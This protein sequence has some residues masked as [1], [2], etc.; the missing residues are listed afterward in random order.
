MIT[1]EQA[2]HD[3]KDPDTLFAEPDLSASVEKFARNEGYGWAGIL[4]QYA[5]YPSRLPVEAVIPH[6]VYLDTERVAEEELEAPVPA[7]LNYPAMRNT[8][9]ERL[10]D[11]VVVPSASPF[12]YA[13][14]LFRREF[15]GPATTDGTIF[16]PAHA[17]ETM[18]WDVD[19]EALVRTLTA[20]DDEHQPV[21]VCMHM[22]EYEKGF[23]RIFADA[24]F[25]VVSAGN[26]WDREFIYRWLHLLSMHRFAASNDVGGC[27]YY[28]VRA[29]TPFFL[30]GDVPKMRL[31]S[32][33]H[34]VQQQVGLFYRATSQQIRQ[35]AAR[36]RATFVDE[37]GTGVTRVELTDYLLGAENLK[38]PEELHAAL[39]EVARLAAR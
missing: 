37:E 12:L 33:L 9:W 4:K 39:E 14:E 36:I 6:G 5:G 15:P 19:W 11:K 25:E 29:G 21:T 1:L 30:L 23:H 34:F 8:T 24:G 16:F 28:S 27:A 38:T 7:V 18:H 32:S 31:D 17:T 2:L 20:L 26:P 10:S 22:A 35:T 13:L 3:Q